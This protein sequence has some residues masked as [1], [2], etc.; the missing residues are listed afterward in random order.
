MNCS[1]DLLVGRVEAGAA[2]VLKVVLKDYC[3]LPVYMCCF[4]QAMEEDK[5]DE[6]FAKKAKRMK[7][8]Q[9]EQ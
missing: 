3:V 6:W 7:H 9:D 5:S 2:S 8:K 1:A 4:V